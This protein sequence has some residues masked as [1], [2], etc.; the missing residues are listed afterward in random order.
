M[1]DPLNAARLKVSDA[2]ARLRTADRAYSDASRE[3]TSARNALNE[4]QKEFDA[5]VEKVR[6][7]A[8]SVGTDWGRS[9]LK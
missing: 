5:A 4:A 7:E 6:G 2:A 8:A 3:Q 9:R 1:T